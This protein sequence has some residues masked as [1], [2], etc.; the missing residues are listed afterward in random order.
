MSAEPDDPDAA[1]QR[2][3]LSEV[4]AVE[5]DTLLEVRDLDA[6]YGD[7]QILDGVDLDVDNEEYVTNELSKLGPTYWRNGQ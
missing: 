2:E 6:G 4:H 5:G 7:L 1:D 3:D